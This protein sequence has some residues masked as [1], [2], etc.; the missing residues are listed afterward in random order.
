MK[1][2]SIQTRMGLIFTAFFAL[3]VISVGATYWSIQSQ[4]Q[5]ALVINL[6]GRQRM[7]S[8]QMTSLTLQIARSGVAAYGPTLA[9]AE[10]AFGQTLLALR[11]GGPAPYLPGSLVELPA[12]HDPAILAQLDQI[13]QA[14]QTFRQNLEVI[15]QADPASAEFSAAGQAIEELSPTLLAQTDQAVRLFEAASTRKIAQLRMLQLGFLASSLLLL[16]LGWWVTQRSLIQPLQALG[17]DAARIGQGNLVT[18]V[19]VRGPAEVQVLSQAMDAMRAQIAASQ[20]ELRAWADTLEQRV[21]LRTQEL[22]ALASVSQDISSKLDIQHVLQSVTTKARQLLQSE[23]AYLC[24]FDPGMQMLNLNSASGPEDAVVQCSTPVQ[25]AVRNHILATEEALKCD[26]GPCHDFCQISAARYRAS[27]L[28]APLR[29]GERVIGTLCVGSQKPNWYTAEAVRM[30]TQLAAIVVVAL[31]NARLYEQAEQAAILEERQRIAADMHDGLLQTLS[32][33]Q[34][35]VRLTKEQIEAANPVSAV[36]TLQHVQ[37]AEEQAEHEIRQAIASLQENFPLQHTLQEQLTAIAAETSQPGRLVEN[38]NIVN[39]PVV[40][41]Q[42]QSEQV[43]R[44]VREAVL[45]AQ[46]HG[47][48]AKTTLSLDRAE[49]DYLVQVTDDGQGFDTASQPTDGRLHFGLKI[50]Q[51]R[52][53]RL[54]GRVTIQS[55]PGQG[56]QVTLRWPVTPQK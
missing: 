14:W 11:D 2:A 47:Q 51:A 24:L 50:M 20:S 54:G 52:A 18:P 56:T 25:A 45:N 16:S 43:L 44:V 35:M 33:M 30:L 23:V 26:S 1:L 41:P 46:R 12:T 49:A 17:A 29:A 40:L 39:R 42:I 55:T 53:A 32:F 34:W 7:L 48:A 4:Q 9:E 5:D 38:V 10:Q 13:A 22:E 15:T 3:A 36:E 6:A 37:R 27:H 31:E 28:T 19:A 8:Q 21:S